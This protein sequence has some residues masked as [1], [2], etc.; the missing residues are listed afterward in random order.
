MVF[1]DL[2]YFFFCGKTKKEIKTKQKRKN[3]SSQKTLKSLQTNNSSFNHRGGFSHN[4][5]DSEFCGTVVTINHVTKVTYGGCHFRFAAVVVIADKQGR[6]G[7]GTVKAN[8]V[9]GA[10]KKQSKRL[11][12]Y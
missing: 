6:F 8:D 11:K 12:N 7:L 10:V 1:F 4:Q 9:P 3:F 2:V 5:A